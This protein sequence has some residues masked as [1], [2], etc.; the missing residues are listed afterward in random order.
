[1]LKKNIEKEYDA[2]LALLKMVMCFFVILAHGWLPNDSGM[3]TSFLN[4]TRKF[5]AVVFMIVAVYFSYP[6]FCC[7]NANKL[8]NRLIRLIIPQ[9]GWSFVYWLFFCVA[10]TLIRHGGSIQADRLF[11]QILFGHSIN[12]PMW[13]QFMLILMTLIFVILFKVFSRKYM[14][15]IIV[16]S[17][18]C[19]FLQYMGINAEIFEGIRSEISI[20]L[21][22]IVE[23]FPVAT[24]G[25]VLAE[26]KLLDILRE[27][28]LITI[29]LSSILLIS[30][31]KMWG[32]VTPKVGFDYQGIGM[33]VGG[34]S[35]I[36]IGASIPVSLTTE[37]GFK[38]F[39]TITGY[40]LGIYCMHRL[41]I[42]VLERLYAYIKFPF[43]MGT[44]ISCVVVYLVC[45]LIAFVATNVLK[46]SWLKMM[47]S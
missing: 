6:L 24:C 37:K 44:V 5:A 10:P 46:R 45:Y 19:I 17:G 23:I 41:V 34:L 43:E 30:I 13:F 47:F 21:G 20:P 4:D 32:V 29:I 12:S 11:L 7:P 14:L 33:I 2:S 36:G 25:I 1:M 22:R 28:R 38:I 26:Y 8:K 16:L 9:I 3:F 39:E 35:I 18:I 27:K 40:T 42:N 15:V 31:E